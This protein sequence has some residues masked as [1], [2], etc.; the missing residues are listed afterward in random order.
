MVYLLGAVYLL[1]PISYLKKFSILP[2]YSFLLIFLAF[3]YWKEKSFITAE[4]FEYSAQFL[5]PIILHLLIRYPHQ[6]KKI[7]YFLLFSIAVTFTA[8]GLY[9]VGFY[10]VPGNFVDMVIVILGVTE[11]IAYKLLFFVGMLDFILAVA[12]FFPFA[13]KAFLSYALLWGLLTSFSRLWAT[14]HPELP[15]YSLHQWIWEVFYRL[16]HAGLPLAA[17]VLS[18]FLHK[19]N[20]I[21]SD[22]PV[23]LSLK[24]I[25]AGK[26]KAET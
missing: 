12:I 3:L 23:K 19:R 21:W 2:V 18:R 13:N 8:H 24:P 22:L 11:E 16:P 14:F 6:E 15:F 10:P 17:L 25:T 9:A 20:A 4:F 26:E 5:L 1:L 7:N